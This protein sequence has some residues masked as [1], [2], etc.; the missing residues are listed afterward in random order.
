MPSGLH[1]NSDWNTKGYFYFGDD[2]GNGGE[3]SYFDEDMEKLIP[4]R[5]Q[6]FGKEPYYKAP[7]DGDAIKTK[8]YHSEYSMGVWEV[9][10]LVPL[11]DHTVI[12]MISNEGDSEAYRTFEEKALQ[13]ARSVVQ[14]DSH[15][16]YTGNCDA[17]NHPFWSLLPK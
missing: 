8:Y 4:R 7:F 5:A 11:E 9:E 15:A 2:F 6:W 16:R 1:A 13:L 14:G 12:I 10:I 3:I 17:N